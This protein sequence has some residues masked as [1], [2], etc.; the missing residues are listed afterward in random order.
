M[1]PRTLAP[2]ALLLAAGCGADNFA[3]VQF[4]EICFPPA[5]KSGSCIYPASCENTLLGR[6][7][8]DVGL[9]SAFELP[10]QVN[11]QLRS[12]AD[13]STGQVNTH[14]AHVQKYA[15]TYGVPGAAL[16]GSISLANDTV[17]AG[18]NTVVL[19]EVLPTV[20]MAQLAAVAPATPTTIVADVVAS[21][22]YDS[23]DTFET[24]PFRIA[25]DVCSGCP[26]LG[27]PVGGLCTGTTVFNGGCPGSAVNGG[28]L[29]SFPF[30]F[31]C[32]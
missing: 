32:Q 18:G 13:T 7:R 11:N 9:A 29:V 16:P 27:F 19:V 4:F 5:P 3:S 20:T 21:G 2:L 31:E 14:D 30:N 15:I 22:R 6:P 17:R 26:D 10:I 24:G 12:N 28:L 23:G 8:V 1:N 25:L